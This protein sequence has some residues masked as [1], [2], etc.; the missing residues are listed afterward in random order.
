MKKLFAATLVFVLVLGCFAGCGNS[1]SADA[2][3]DLAYIQE[4]GTM[5]VGITEYEPMDY[6]DENGQWIGFDADLANM[7]A[8][9]LGV[10]A[11]FLVLADWGQKYYE[12][13]TRNIDV[14]WNGMTITEEAKL[15]TNVTDAYAINAQVVVMKADKAPDYAEADS[16]KDLKFAVESGSAGE[17]LLQ[18]KGMTDLVAVQDQP[19]AIMEVAAGTADACVIDITMA[20]AMTG[21]GTSYEDLAVAQTLNEEQYGIGFRKDSDVTA[22]VNELLAQYKTDGTLQKLSDTY[23]VAAAK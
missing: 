6:Q 13:E 5:I 1:A 2:E 10:K 23:G 15:N 18:D 19:A 11:E 4:K 8:K 14:I 16:L 3:S 21:A 17:A 9:E 7:V 22:K 12:L 20:N